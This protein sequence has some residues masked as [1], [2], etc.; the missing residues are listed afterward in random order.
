MWASTM[1][2]FE[3]C[4]VKE[5]IA[6]KK[7]GV[8][9]VPRHVII[10]A[11]SATCTNLPM[12]QLPNNMPFYPADQKT[13]LFMDEDFTQ[14]VILP[15]YVLVLPNNDFRSLS[16]QRLVGVSI[17]FSIESNTSSFIESLRHPDDKLMRSAE[18]YAVDKDPMIGRT[19]QVQGYYVTMDFNEQ[20]LGLGQALKIWLLVGL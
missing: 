7:Q 17:N 18:S 6:D 14:H 9:G 15:S 2:I 8:V 19:A 13:Y 10:A 3:Q 20:K 16:H 11:H 5:I 1:R 12:K 4:F